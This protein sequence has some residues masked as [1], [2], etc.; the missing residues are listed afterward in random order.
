MDEVVD[1]DGDGAGAVGAGAGAGEDGED[2]EEELGR[3]T[4]A[5]TK[6]RRLMMRDASSLLCHSSK[7]DLHCADAR[8]CLTASY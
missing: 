4:S 1:G 5:S 3:R 6:T 8:T 2:G 7:R